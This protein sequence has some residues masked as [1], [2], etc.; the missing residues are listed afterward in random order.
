MDEQRIISIGQKPPQFFNLYLWLG[1][2]SNCAILPNQTTYHERCP[3]GKFWL[4]NYLVACERHNA[5]NVV[6][7]LTFFFQYTILS[8]KGVILALAFEP[9]VPCDCSQVQNSSEIFIQNGWKLD[10]GCFKLY[11][12]ES[13]TAVGLTHKFTNWSKCW[14]TEC[15]FNILNPVFTQKYLCGRSNSI[16]GI[17]AYDAVP[18]VSMVS[19]KVIFMIY[20]TICLTVE[21]VLNNHSFCQK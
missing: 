17:H 5:G 16:H 11:W 14:W 20:P 9:K 1:T 13:I 18:A 15:I 19:W 7:C 8:K 3:T 4:L 12:Q 6:F 10:Y 21:P 2:L